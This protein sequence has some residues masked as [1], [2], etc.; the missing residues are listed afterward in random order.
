VDDDGDSLET[1]LECTNVVSQD[2]DADGA[3]N[4]YDLDSD[5]DG[6]S[7]AMEGTLDTDD[8]AVPDFLDSTATPKDSDRDGVAD[9]RECELP[10]LGCPDVDGDGMP[11]Y[12]DDDDDGDG[13]LTPAESGDSDGDGTPDYLDDDDDGD[14]LLT[15]S[16][17]RTDSDE[18]GLS[19]YL[20]ADDDGDGL[21]TRSEGTADRDADGVPDYLDAQHNGPVDAGVPSQ[22]GGVQGFDGATLNTRAGASAG[23]SLAQ[24]PH[25]ALSALLLLACAALFRRRL[26]LAALLASGCDDDAAPQTSIGLD[27]AVLLDAASRADGSSLA[28]AVVEGCTSSELSFLTGDTDARSFSA[29]IEGNRVQLAFIAPSCGGATS[30]GQGKGVRTVSFSSTG[31]AL[32]PMGVDEQDCVPLREP[33]LLP[34]TLYFGSARDGQFDLYHAER[35]LTHTPELELELNAVMLGE[36]PA[37]VFVP[38]STLH[39]T[40]PASIQRLAGDGTREL[41]SAEAG[42]HPVQVT[43]REELLGWRSDREGTQGLYMRALDGSI[44]TLTRQVGPRSSLAFVAGGVVY[45]ESSGGKHV[46]RY[47]ALA[48]GEPRALTA[49]NQ[50]VQQFAASH[51]RT[52]HAVAYRN[53]EPDGSFTLRLLSLD[54]QGNV[55]ANTT[56]ASVSGDGTHVQLLTSLDGRLIVLWDESDAGL[57]D[58]NRR[59]RVGR[60]SCI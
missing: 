23:C 35:K 59:L 27:A 31:E 34:S 11:D 48:S 3:W 32:Q 17:G 54:A 38:Q 58:F 50:D 39:S 24:S 43:V 29:V 16:E 30:L 20:D 22:E 60:T 55:A 46:L 44:V 18:D 14:G 19:D 9:V 49:D 33:T 15:R 13:L 6:A 53:L 2:V 40:D 36:L 10:L 45:T 51:Y 4:C 26:A 21:S 7:D 37:I 41:L 56:F 12:L 52:G 57:P 28:D 47:R 42:H 25:S 5:G 1:R 8:D